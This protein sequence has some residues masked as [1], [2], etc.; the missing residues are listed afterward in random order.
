[1]YINK[2]IIL[3]FFKCLKFITLLFDKYFKF[4]EKLKKIKIIL[5]RI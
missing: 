1:M 5:S 2:N 4:V 3:V